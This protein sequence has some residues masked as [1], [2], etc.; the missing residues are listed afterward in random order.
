MFKK[1]KNNW[2]VVL[3]SLIT[4]GLAVLTFVTSQQLTRTSPVAPNVPQVTPKAA[5]PA[6]TLSFVIATPTPTNVVSGTPT[7]TP[8]ST[9]SNTPTPTPTS[10]VGC[11]STCTVNSDCNNGL[12][13]V[14]SSCRNQSCTDSTSCSCSSATPTPTPVLSSCNSGCTVNTDCSSGLVCISGSCRNPSCTDKT[15][16]T[17]TV[18]TPT[19]NTP[20]TG[21]GPSVLG[22]SV[23]GSGFLLILLGFAL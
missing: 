3:I 1:A 20:V 16:C 23:I 19:P 21:N 12:V 4:V 6:C 11:N 5:E 8:T 15:T 14:A 9:P 2:Y 7:N 10:T 13:C 17:C 18:A 22:A